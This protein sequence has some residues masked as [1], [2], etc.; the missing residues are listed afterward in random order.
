MEFSSTLNAFI[1][2]SNGWKHECFIKSH[3]CGR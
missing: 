1:S 3:N 2:S